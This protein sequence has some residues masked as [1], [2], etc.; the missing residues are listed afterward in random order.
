MIMFQKYMTS[1]ETDSGSYPMSLKTVT[2]EYRERF[3]SKTPKSA[4][5]YRRNVSLAPHGVHSN[6][7]IFDPHPIFMARGKGSRI[8]D[9]DGNEYIDYNMAFGALA[10]GH[11]H[12]ILVERI[13]ERIENGTVFGFET[14]YGVKL[15]EVLL[16]RFGFE[17]IRFS[18]T[19]LEGTQL[20]V[21]L[22][23]AATN[24]PKILK[25]EGCYHGSHDSLLVGVK[26]D[27]LHA[28]H[29]K[30]PRSVPAGPGIPK[31]IAD[32][33]V[34]APFNDIYAVE[35]IMRQHGNDIA[36]IILEPIPMNMGVVLPKKGFLEG[37][38]K[39]AD[40]YNS[41]L[42]FDE[43]KTSGKFYRGAQDYFGVKPDIIVVAKALGGGYPF[44][45][46][47]AKKDLMELIG[48]RKVAH[49][50]TFNSNPL[51]VY[52]AYITVT[53]I[54]TEQNLAYAQKLSDELAKGYRDV[55]EDKRVDAHVVDI[56]T[57][58]TV[59]FT[60]E[61][62]SNWRDF[63]LKVNW[64]RWYAWVLGMLINGVIPQALGID[65]QWTVSIQHTKEDIQKT[66]EMFDKVL[67]EIK[68]RETVPVKVEEAI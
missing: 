43:V 36:A 51:S 31:D 24:R 60:K 41:L 44:S 54:L 28:G 52:A 16:K 47:M 33:V 14:K 3:I 65:E 2:E 27:P 30:K 6:W 62:I 21:R 42:I 26:P 18:S 58:G 40:E 56:A 37:L 12:P 7:R 64:G 8:W 68:G 10:I 48:P 53:E 11:A 23:R 4:E 49:G 63:V 67:S 57:S 22:A 50:G 1:H 5:L 32:Q 29:P 39:L 15:A 35:D 13:R 46:V 66:V 55:I 19:G 34:I 20:A 17:M 38:R 61:E 25:F 9:V 59:F 45:A